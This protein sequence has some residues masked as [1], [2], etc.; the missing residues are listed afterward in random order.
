M[1]CPWRNLVGPVWTRL[2]V[3]ARDVGVPIA[4]TPVGLRSG[5]LKLQGFNLGEH[6]CL[7]QLFDHGCWHGFIDIEK[8]DGL[9]SSAFPT[10][11]EVRDIH[12]A[13]AHCLAK[14]ADDAGQLDLWSYDSETGEGQLLVSSTDLLGAPE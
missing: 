7:F 5:D 8:R 10:Q 11:G 13:C 2:D 3:Q 6:A 9:F 4:G 12:A 14:R 1:G